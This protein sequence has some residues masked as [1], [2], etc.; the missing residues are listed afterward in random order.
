MSAPVVI[1]ARAAVRAEIGGVERVAREMASRLPELDPARYRVV[2]PPRALAHRAGHAW[3]Q[4]LLPLGA[5]GSS[6]IYSPANLAPVVSRKNAVVIHDVAP[7]RLPE[8]F[9]PGYLAYQRRLLPLLARRARLLLTVSDFSR[10]ELIECLDAPPERVRVV[11]NGVDDRFSPDSDPAPARA[12]HGLERPYALAV[13]TLSGRKNLPALEAA[14]A[15]LRENGIDLVVAG[16]GR[17]YLRGGAP[18]GLRLLGYVDETLLP[19]LYAGASAVAVP[20]LYEGFGLPCLEAMAS[21]TPVVASNRG[22]LPETCGEAALLIDPE[23][24]PAFADALLAAATDEDLRARLKRDG[25]ERAAG[26]SWERA[27]QG[28]HAALGEVLAGG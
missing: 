18:R 24:A 1:N 22:A 28:T 8:A 12:R 17:H 3:E 20:S 10:G 15:L 26:F 19:G 27:A 4:V 13:G 14:A 2:R 7:L 11:H 25:L 6:L 5:A 23:D 9:S 21:G 16:S